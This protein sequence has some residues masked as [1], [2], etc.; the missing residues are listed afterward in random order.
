MDVGK[1]E[2]EVELADCNDVAIAQGALALDAVT[3]YKN[4]ESAAFVDD[5]GGDGD[6]V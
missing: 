5:V 6:G 4:A 3:R 2:S 1:R